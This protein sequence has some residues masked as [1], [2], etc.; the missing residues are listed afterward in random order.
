[1]NV[2][3]VVFG[4]CIGDALGL[5]TEFMKKDEIKLKYPNVDYFKY[6]DIV[7][8]Y[9]RTAWKKG[10][11][12]DD[13]DQMLIILKCI[14]EN[15]L[16]KENFA[17]K[18]NDWYHNGHP[19][20]GDTN[21]AGI[22][23]TVRWVINEE[24]FVTNPH[25]AS[26][27]I[28]ETTM[29]SSASNGAV[30]RTSIIGILDSVDEVVEKSVEIC[31]CT[32][33]DVKCRISCIFISCLVHYLIRDTDIRNSII[34]SKKQVFD[35]LKLTIKYKEEWGAITDKNYFNKAWNEFEK[36]IRI[37]D[38]KELNLEE[39]IGYTFK[40]VGCAIWAL[41]SKKTYQEAINEIIFEGGD[42]DTNAA[43]AG[44][45][46]GSYVKFRRFPEHLVDGLVFKTEL[47]KYCQILNDR[48][49]KT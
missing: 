19:E 38:L 8:D 46:L 24:D 26:R 35:Y 27:M 2:K 18:L 21:S 9:H 47:E 33:Y 17:K 10:D 39:H 14:L 34:N 11:W 25:K 7:Q 45:I 31:K 41:T 23:N 3:G 32:H 42:S 22:G 30:M 36:T 43:V 15:N 12:T 29:C 1:M 28:W 37:H 44:A 5:A 49:T 13:S 6:S 40:P 20:F 16:T 48:F 4:Q